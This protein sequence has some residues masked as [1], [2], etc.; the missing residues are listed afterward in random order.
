MLCKTRHFLKYH[1][2]LLTIVLLDLAFRAIFFSIAPYFW[3]A[4]TLSTLCVSLV[5]TLLCYSPVLSQL[6][7]WDTWDEMLEKNGTVTPRHII[8]N[9]DFYYIVTW[10]YYCCK[11]C[12]STFRGWNKCILNSLPPYLCLAFPA[13][14]SHKVGVSKTVIT[15]LCVRLAQVV[16][17]HSFLSGIPY[18]STHCNFNM[19]NLF[20]S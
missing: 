20:L 15:Q 12:K 17:I 14:L 18:V 13:V 6:Y 16:F 7:Q 5:A 2:P 4:H 10:W 9:D 3:P 1:N 19:P 8:D 11:G